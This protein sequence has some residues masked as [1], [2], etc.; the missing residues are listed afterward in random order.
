LQQRLVKTG[1]RLVRHARYYCLML[2][3]S[4]LTR[5]LSA[6]REHG[7]A[8]RCEGGGWV[9][10]GDDTAKPADQDVRDEGVPVEDIEKT[11]ISDFEFC[12]QREISVLQ[13][14]KRLREE[15]C[16]SQDQRMAFGLIR[17]GIWKSKIKIPVYL[18]L[19]YRATTA[20][21]RRANS[22]LPVRRKA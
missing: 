22:L 15:E 20:G 4:H 18:I 8:D 17:N 6:V 21:Q 13:G 7:S 5:R 19:Q 11:W 12:E 16:G 3:E 9:A 1:G 2:A 10:V 14:R